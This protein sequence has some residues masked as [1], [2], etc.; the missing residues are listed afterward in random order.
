MD[1]RRTG[2]VIEEIDDKKIRI[3]TKT[4]TSSDSVYIHQ[5]GSYSFIYNVRGCE[6]SKADLYAWLTNADTGEIMGSQDLIYRARNIQWT[7]EAR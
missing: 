1:V 4:M 3:E 7:V 5:G 2:G 6:G